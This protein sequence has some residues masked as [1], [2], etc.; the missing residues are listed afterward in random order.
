MKTKKRHF[1][2]LKSGSKAQVRE[3]QGWEGGLAPARRGEQHASKNS[4][5]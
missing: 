1:K 4:K 3:A 2:N 5:E